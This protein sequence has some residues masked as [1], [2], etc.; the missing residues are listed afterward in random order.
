METHSGF[1]VLAISQVETGLTEEVT[2]D[3]FFSKAATLTT[4]KK[5]NDKIMTQS[6]SKALM[7]T[8]IWHSFFL[9]YP[10]KSGG[11]MAPYSV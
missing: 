2:S 6:A 5:E 7:V 3:F 8:F 4:F 10:C 1:T 9:L 11:T